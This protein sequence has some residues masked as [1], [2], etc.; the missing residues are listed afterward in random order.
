MAV[1]LRPYQEEALVGIRAEIFKGHKRIV[2]VIATGGGKTTVAAELIKGAVAKSNPVL[3]LA[4]RTELIDQASAR[5]D[6]Y[7]IDHGIIQAGTLR[8]KPRALVQVAS[9]QTLGNRSLPPA[10]MIIVD[11]GHRTLGKSYL[12]ILA[13]YPDALVLLLTATPIRL[14]GRGLGDVCTAM[15]EPVT[16][17]ELIDQGTLIEPRVFVPS[18]P[19]LSKVK[20]DKGDYHQGQLA[21]LM[22][23]PHLVGDVV[24]TWREKAAGRPTVVF[25][26]SV[27]HSMHLRDAFKEAGVRAEHIDGNTNKAMRKSVI[28]LLNTGMV[29][30]VCNVGVLTEGW[31]YPPLSCVVLAR[32]TKSLSLYLQMIGRGSRPSPETGKTDFL[33]L[34]HAG[35]TF[36]H[37]LMGDV[38]EWTLD[39]KKKKKP[40]APS[41]KN[42]PSCFAVC[43]SGTMQCPECGYTW[44]KPKEATRSNLPETRDGRL[45]E[46]GKK[47]CPQCDAD[48]VEEAATVCMWCGHVFEVKKKPHWL[49]RFKPAEGEEWTEERKRALFDYLCDY[50][51]RKGYKAGYVGIQYKNLVGK[52]PP[53]VWPNPIKELE[54]KREMEAAIL[55]PQYSTPERVNGVAI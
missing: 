20:I 55:M 10:T 54:R 13:A 46:F 36:E 49:D 50:G 11:E 1:K 29:E 43:A 2:L 17:R 42:C 18:K 5:L 15:V 3:F 41:I 48:D 30:V 51:M 22:D 4:H 19:D 31:D 12:K 35:C 44:D 38:R 25:A 8:A 27:E 39:P 40:A 7:D 37:G 32:P 45:V 52:W 23:T 26:S 14:D 47:F 53:K 24:G 9:V 33:V 34:D 6:T 21:A 28:Q 16:V